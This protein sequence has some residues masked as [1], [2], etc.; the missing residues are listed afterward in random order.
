ML[1][2]VRFK[3]LLSHRH[4]HPNTFTG[5][6]TIACW[7]NDQNMACGLAV[8]A[9]SL[10]CVQQGRAVMNNGGKGRPRAR[11]WVERHIAGSIAQCSWQANRLNQFFC[12]V[13]VASRC[14]QARTDSARRPFRF[15]SMRFPSARY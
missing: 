4:Q 8:K 7:S 10:C 2:N 12:F 9:L 5:V 14:S 15:F 13:S 11:Q 1:T 3:G 6:S